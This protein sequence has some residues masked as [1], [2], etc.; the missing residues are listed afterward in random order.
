ML[1]LKPRPQ[2][3]SAG[4][5]LEISHLRRQASALRARAALSPAMRQKDSPSPEKAAIAALDEEWFTGV[6]RQAQILDWAATN[7]TWTAAFIAIML[8]ENSG[9][10]FWYGL[11]PLSIQN[12]STQFQGIILVSCWVNGILSTLV[13]LLIL[14]RSLDGGST[15]A[16]RLQNALPWLPLP[17]A[18]GLRNATSQ[19]TQ[20]RIEKET[21]AGKSEVTEE[22]VWGQP[23]P[24]QSE[25]PSFGRGM[26]QLEMQEEVSSDEEKR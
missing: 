24:S 13:A 16:Q 6:K 22:S 7:R 23:L 9:L 19:R 20:T 15:A 1:M 18:V 8:L 5:Y 3:Y 25:M 12:N 17:P 21:Y 2:I 14:F 11:A 26:V 4:A 10:C